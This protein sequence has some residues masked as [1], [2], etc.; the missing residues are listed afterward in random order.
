VYGVRRA[1]A[2]LLGGDLVPLDARAVG[3]V[4]RQGGTFLRTARCSEFRTLEGQQKGF[5]VLRE[6]GIDALVVCGGDGSLRG[7]EALLRLDYPCI[8]IP[9][10]I[11]NDLIGTDEAIGVD[12]ALNTALEA[13]DKIKDTASAM[14]RVFVVEVMG[15]H[16]GYLALMAGIAGGAEIVLV[17]E[18][19][20][21]LGDVLD[22]LEEQRARGKPHFIAVV[23]EGATPRASDLV[24]EI[25][26][27]AERGD[28]E[29]RLTVIGHVQRGGSP[30]A[31]DRLLASRLGS[32]AVQRLKEGVTGEMVG[33]VGGKIAFTPIPKVTTTPRP[34]DTEFYELSQ[35]LAL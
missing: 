26:Q 35:V 28:L 2:G 19:P 25:E 33:L 30:T 13:I 34:L 12:T 27:S 14:G 21:T 29:A 16:C 3:G 6:H 10:T 20:V 11:D 5:A 22:E 18:A 8:G 17:P 9:G 31:G 15:R 7:A 4:L 32:A 24:D 1:Y 23:A